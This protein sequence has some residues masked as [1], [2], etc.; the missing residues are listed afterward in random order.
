MSVF[1]TLA[2]RKPGA[3]GSVNAPPPEHQTQRAVKRC[4]SA[5]L[6]GQCLQFFLVGLRRHVFQIE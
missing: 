5:R 4:N 6:H 3:V 2:P 1:F